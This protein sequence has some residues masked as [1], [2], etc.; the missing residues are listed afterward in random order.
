MR[1]VK[2]PDIKIA[3]EEL[4]I[5]L[6]YKNGA[7]KY[8]LELEEEKKLEVIY[9]E[10]EDLKGVANDKFKSDILKSATNDAIYNAYDETQENNRLYS[11]RSRILL[12]VTRCPYCGI[13]DADEL[14]HHL[15]RSI[16][17]AIAVY[18]SNLIPL[19]HKCNNKKRTITGEKIEERFTHVYFDE[20]PDS[21]LLLADITINDDALSV[22]FKINEVGIS[23]LRFK[24]LSFQ[25]GRINLNGRL[26]KECNVY[27]SSI[28]SMIEDAYGDNNT[29]KLKE[30]LISQHDTNKRIFGINDW[31][32]VFLFSLANCED[33]CGGGFKAILN[34]L[35]PQ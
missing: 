9:K 31:R 26:V 13:S 7:F 5:A 32:T 29:D 27:L 21:P 20:F 12:S 6:T 19:C 25:I 34:K 4:K 2:A 8:E 17:K 14:D 1:K 23:E 33:F 24:Q 10:Y 30:L 16:Y 3:L 11:L 22:K 35:Y 15:P 28:A 18:V